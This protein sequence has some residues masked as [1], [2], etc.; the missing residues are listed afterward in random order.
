MSSRHAVNPL[1]D[2]EQG[3]G[4]R[5]R[6]WAKRD[7]RGISRCHLQNECSESS[8]QAEQE[9][10]HSHQATLREQSTNEPYRGKS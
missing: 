7:E 6:T 5:A 9:Y 8:E 4:G 1:D 2:N 3:E 10:V